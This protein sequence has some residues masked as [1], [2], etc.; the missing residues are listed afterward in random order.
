[1]PL[2]VNASHPKKPRQGSSS[3]PDPPRVGARSL[4]MYGPHWENRFI[5]DESAADRVAHVILPSGRTYGLGYDANENRTSITMPSGA[6]HALGYNKVNLDNTYIPPG[7]PAYATAYNLDREWAQTPITSGRA[8]DAAYDNGGKAFR[9]ELPRGRRNLCPHRQHGPGL[10]DHPCG[11]G[12]AP[13]GQAARSSRP[14]PQGGSPRQ[15]QDQHRRRVCS[16]VLRARA[17]ALSRGLRFLRAEPLM[18]GPRRPI[19]R[20]IIC[21]G[22]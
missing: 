11:P 12:A 8:I 3:N 10:F 7:I 1:M 17:P 21:G 6:V 5:C 22:E 18:N 15:E 19:M 4:P 16:C 14:P 9:D 2:R 20:Y 13:P